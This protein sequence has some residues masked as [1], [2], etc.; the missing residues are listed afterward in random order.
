MF[1]TNQKAGGLQF[2]CFSLKLKK[3]L[4]T[5]PGSHKNNPGPEETAMFTQLG[6]TRL[7]SMLTGIFLLVS[8]LWLFFPKPF[9]LTTS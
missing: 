5:R 3:I 8:A 7:S 1:K 2:I 4:I 9:L 6:I